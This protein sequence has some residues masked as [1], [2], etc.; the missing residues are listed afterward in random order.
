M[1]DFVGDPPIA[2]DVG[3]VWDY[4]GLTRKTSWG[5]YSVG[6]PEKVQDGASHRK[7]RTIYFIP[8]CPGGLIEPIG[9]WSI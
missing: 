1:N 3:T 8:P 2:A 6:V 7:K 9:I 4:T 5:D